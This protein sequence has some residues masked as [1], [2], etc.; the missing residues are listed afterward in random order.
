MT[1]I[2]LRM[3]CVRYSWAADVARGVDCLEIGSG[4]GFG[5]NLISAGARSAVGGDVTAS[6]L[7]QSRVHYPDCNV[8]RFDAHELPFAD[9]SFDVVAMFEVI[10]YLA[11]IPGVLSE[12]RRVLRPG[13]EVLICL[14]NRE[15]PGFHRSPK[16][17]TYPSARELHEILGE[18]SFD[19]D[20]FAGF[21][22][23]ELGMVDKVLVAGATAGRRLHIIP[24]TLRARSRIKRLVH[25]KMRTLQDLQEVDPWEEL[26]P[27]N[28]S[29]PVRDF[30]NLYALGRLRKE[31][32]DE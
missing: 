31:L 28:W 29:A 11:D 2:Q 10:Y 23:G 20:V 6:N 14:P 24:G 9:S 19:T 4:S 12:I 27:V 26:V 18:A 21:R 8:A 30:K 13:G 32:L 3:A 15:R 16:S 22:M 1:D 17:F 7:R 5:L 25:G